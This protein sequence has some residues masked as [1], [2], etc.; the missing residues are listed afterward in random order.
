L[1]FF[2]LFRKESADE[3]IFYRA[4]FSRHWHGLFRPAGLQRRRGAEAGREE[5]TATARGQEGGEVYQLMS[6]HQLSR[7]VSFQSVTN[8]WP[9]LWVTQI[10]GLVCMATACGVTPHAQKTGTS[11]GR[12]VTASPKSGRAR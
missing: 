10:G 3:T 1:L 2:L 9:G 7:S 11:P 5:R 8:I 4:A 6:A 12:I